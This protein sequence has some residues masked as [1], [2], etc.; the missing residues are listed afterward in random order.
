MAEC[1]LNEVGAERRVNEKLFS[2]PWNET[3]GERRALFA[4]L[5]R[6]GGRAENQRSVLTNERS[7]GQRFPIYIADTHKLA[8]IPGCQGVS[9]L[10]VA[11]FGVRYYL[12]APRL[13]CISWMFARLLVV[14][15]K[16]KRV[17]FSHSF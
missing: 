4:A 12:T 11:A 14:R 3:E 8:C 17:Y 13:R 5:E 16:N 10:G 9:V 15:C 6:N 2:L 1:A 7:R